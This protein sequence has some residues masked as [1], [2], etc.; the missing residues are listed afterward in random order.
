MKKLF[1]FALCFF[2]ALS[3]KAST[4]YSLVF[5]HLGT[6]VPSYLGY[7]VKQAR[8]FNPTCPIYLLTDNEEILSGTI[9]IDALVVSANSLKP[10]T[11]HYLFRQKTTLDKHFRNGFWL[12]A[13]ERFL[14]LHDFMEQYN[15][16]NVF[17]LE[18]DTLLYA[19]LEELL[20]VFLK[21]YPHIGAVFDNDERCIPCFVYFAA[22]SDAAKLSACFTRH[23][24][25]GANDMVV[26]GC[27]KKES[28]SFIETLPIIMPDYIEM[29][30][31]KSPSGHTTKTPALYANHINEFNSI[32]DAA[33][34]GQF[35]GGIDPRNG[36]SKPGFI[37]ESCLFNPSL[38]S[39]SWEKDPQNRTIPYAIFD[40]KKYK[41]NTLHIHSKKLE[42]FTSKG[43]NY[44]DQATHTL[45]NTSFMCNDAIAH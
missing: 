37:N 38:L 17:H 9:N 32:F 26:L 14:V 18:N 24:T 25:S 22:A 44:E 1:A 7:A 3:T 45:T 31:L 19:N 11:D 10:S 39:F 15:L 20:P 30:G 28:P 2:F 6:N 5:I 4:P 36:Q 16:E 12:N 40:G 29:I 21:N 42:L 8:L 23:A 43:A 34:L 27:F 35:L 13:S 33:A 41:I